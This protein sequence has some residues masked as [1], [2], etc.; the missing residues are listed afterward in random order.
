[1]RFR[2]WPVL[3]GGILVVL[4][5]LCIAQPGAALASVAWIV[6]LLTLASGVSS[7]LFALRAEAFLPNAGTRTLCA[8]FRIVLGLLFLCNGI[9]LAVSLAVLFAFWIVFE[10]LRLI[11]QALSLRRAGTGG[12]QFACGLGIGGVL[13]GVGILRQPET[14]VATLGTL[15]GLA[16]LAAGSFR[17]IA[18]FCRRPR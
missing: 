3:S 4:G 9:L 10:S 5:V 18:F 15:I 17:L 7:L 8:I 14:A 12:W 11:V 16:V 13:L 1:M 2:H 6:G